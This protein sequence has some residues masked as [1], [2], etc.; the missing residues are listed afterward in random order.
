MPARLVRIP[1]QHQLDALA[2]HVKALQAADR[3]VLVITTHHTA[4]VLLRRFTDRGVDP[5]RLFIV[6]AVGSQSGVLASS[7]PDHLMYISGPDQL[8]LMALRAAKVIRAKAERTPHVLVCTVNS[9]ALYN[10]PA[11]LEELML[12]VVQSLMRPRAFLDFLVEEGRPLDPGLSTALLKAADERGHL[13]A[14]G[15]YVAE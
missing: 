13:A 5:K 11:A 1:V 4:Q 14:D 7:D 2:G 10:K 15:T 8:E 3:S 9:F 6:D 12:Y